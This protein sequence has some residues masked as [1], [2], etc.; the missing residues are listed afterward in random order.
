MFYTLIKM[1][2]TWKS[3]NPAILCRIVSGCSIYA[4]FR[5]NPA[6]GISG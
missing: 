6:I 2:Y 1:F 4:V 3:G 5:G